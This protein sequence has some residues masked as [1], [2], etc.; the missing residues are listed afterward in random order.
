MQQNRQ[1]EVSYVLQPR[2]HTECNLIME[3][4]NSVMHFTKNKT[5]LYKI[6]DSNYFKPSYC[7]E[8]S[9][10]RLKHENSYFS[11][12]VPEVSFSDIPLSRV[13]IHV[14]KY[15]YYGIAL[16]KEWAI[17]KGLSPIIY[18]EKSSK[19]AEAVTEIEYLISTVL[20]NGELNEWANYK[21]EKLQKEYIRLLSFMKNYSND[22]NRKGKFIKDYRFYDE[23]EWR[24]IPDDLETKIL[25]FG[26][27]EDKSTLNAT[28]SDKGKLPFSYD[29]INF[30]ILKN[31]KDV[32]KFVD[33][34]SDKIDCLA[35][36]IITVEQLLEF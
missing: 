12:G 35:A 26:D 2:E 19:L 4:S 16:K 23:R 11:L 25:S 8:E 28:I 9:A 17:Q 32:K 20:A 24:Y 5:T 18:M 36:K 29:D 10:V 3:S 13:L 6:L 27:F 14:K 21:T 30:V 15:G 1:W 33:R 22:L 34:Y 31:N 7:K